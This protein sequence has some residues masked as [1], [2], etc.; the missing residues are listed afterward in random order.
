VS[1]SETEGLVSKKKPASYVIKCKCMRCGL[2]F[3][4]YSWDWDWRPACCPECGQQEGAFVIWREP[5]E[6][7]IFEHVPGRAELT[8]MGLPA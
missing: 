5:S 2:H 4:G 1:Q 7:Q 3:A 6:Q 8:D